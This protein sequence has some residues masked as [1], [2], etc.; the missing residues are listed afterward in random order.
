MST[1]PSLQT[2]LDAAGGP[3]PA[4]RGLAS[5]HP[6]ARTALPGL[7]GEFTNWRHEQAAWHTTAAFL[8]QSHHMVDLFVEGPD[9]LRLFRDLG[10][11]SFEDFTPGKAKQFIAVSETGHLIGDAVL[12]HLEEHSFDLVGFPYVARWVQFHVESGH[13]DVRSTWD[14][15]AAVRQGT[16]PLLYRYEVQGPAAIRILEDACG[17]SLEDVRFFHMTDVT[18]GGHRVRALRHGMAGQKGF[19]VFGPWAEGEAVRAALLEAGEAHGMQLVGSRAYF[20]ANLESGWVPLPLPAV[21]GPSMRAYR[22]WAAP[23]VPSIGGS[24]VSD[25]VNDYLLTPYELGYGQ[26]VDFDHDFVGREALE[27]IA[28]G[29][30]R[31]KVS[32]IWNEEDLASVFA[33]LFVGDEPPVRYMELPKPRYARFMY[34]TVLVDGQHVGLSLDMGYLAPH[35]TFLSIGTIDEQFAT[36]G[37]EVTVVWGDG[38]AAVGD[39]GDERQLAIRATVAP[40]PFTAYAREQYRNG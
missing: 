4:M 23:D 27:R 5:E 7:V 28:D 34:D 31:Q 36:P 1:S 17:E 13:Y 16:P 21:Y 29:P 30:H 20:T 24:F 22:E 35:K 14:D 12:F 10:V 40:A 8:N 19:E 18:I 25:D 38:R 39:P 32:F 15:N 6:I 33:S 2:E 11:N 3:L 9:A 37:T 26:F